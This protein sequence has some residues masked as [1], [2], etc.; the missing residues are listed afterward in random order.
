MSAPILEEKTTERTV[1]FPEV[2]WVD[3]QTGER[4]KPGVHK[5]KAS[6]TDPVPLFIR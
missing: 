2:D 3:L 4:Y 6:L 1:Y 5:I